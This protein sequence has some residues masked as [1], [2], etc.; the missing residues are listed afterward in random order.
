MKNKKIKKAIILTAGLGSRLKPLTDE[1]PKCLTEVNGIPILEQ[2]L[3]ILE[4]NGIEETVIVIGYLGDV[5][6]KKMGNR[7]GN[8]RISYIWNRIYDETNTMYSAWL[9]RKYLKQGAIM[10]EGDSVFEEGLI[11]KAL[12]TPSNKTY[13][14]GDRFNENFTGSMSTTDKKG[15][16]VNTKIVRGR[17]GEYKPNFY[18]STG[19]LKITP[20]YGKVFSKWLEQDIKKGEVKIYYDLVI[21]KHL[22]DAPIFIYD[23]TEKSRWAEIDNLED[24]ERA[25]VLFKP[26]KYVI[27]LMDGAADLPIPELG[28]KTP[29]EAAQIPNID[30]LA[31]H[32]KTGLMRTMY[33]GL[34]V[35]SIVANL[36]VLG[37]N[38]ARYYPNG[39]ATF[40]ALAQNIFLDK[41]DIAFRCNLV[42]LQND[43]LKDFTASHLPDKDARNL[44]SNLKLPNSKLEIYPGQS[45]RNLLILRNVKL[46]AG[47]I[48]APEPHMNIGKPIKEIL[49]KGN[50][51]RGKK[52]SC[53]LNKF[54][55][56]SISQ[57]KELNKKFKTSADMIFLWSPSS[58]P[59]LFSFHR[60]FGIDGAV[61][62]GL[63]FMRGIGIVARM[64][65][66]KTP[67]ATG[68]SNTNLMAKLKDAQNHL[69]YNDLVYLHINAPDEESHD[70][71]IKGKIKIIER[72]DK[73]IVG[74]MLK[75]LNQKFPNR[76][77]IAVLPDHYTL[78]KD[79][80]HSDQLVPYLVYG[81]DIKKD[82]VQR[83][84]EKDIGGKSRTIIKSYEFMDFLLYE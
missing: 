54:I 27:V 47:E 14:I 31:E 77:R 19:V 36:G 7:C 4:K 59:K 28:N 75:F 12:A 48:E 79:G 15:R 45:Y 33:P 18:K 51:A 39:R 73:E 49:L 13:W 71:K 34:P 2:N 68:E 56:D 53:F 76:Y 83:F 50:T 24:L 64:E 29:L 82:R 40:E 37:Y 23:I 8:M 80:T 20:E 3:R 63:D 6:I 5:I 72:I 65:N 10:I 9:A 74:P 1:V 60:K 70:K 32:G 22:K 81:E 78:L 41:N 46:N 16:I 11:K 52:V 67:G 58:A 42:S 25:E 38:P 61:V 35:C 55:L 57:I 26:T 44:L 21:A 17:L 84:N 69:I 30:Y 62:S 66:K 43:K